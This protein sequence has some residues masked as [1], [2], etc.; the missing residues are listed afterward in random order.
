MSD[1]W[2]QRSIRP[3]RMI[4]EEKQA[5]IEFL[6]RVAALA[7]YVFINLLILSKYSVRYGA[8]V[9]LSCS[10]YV[11][12]LAGAVWIVARDAVLKFLAP[13]IRYFLMVGI[14]S[15]GLALFLSYFNPGEIRV[16]R[17]PAI[18]GWLQD[19][20]SGTYPYG[21]KTHPS[22]FPVLFLVAL[23][24]YW[25]GDTGLWQ[26]ASFAVFAFTLS[27]W[28]PKRRVLGVLLLAGSPAFL[29]EVAVRSDVFSNMVLVLLYLQLVIP[30]TSTQSMRK[31]FAVG[32]LGGLILS[33]RAVVTLTYAVLFLRAARVDLR[34]SLVLASGWAMAFTAS[35]LPFLLWNTD[36]FLASG[37]FVIQSSYLPF[38]VILGL[39]MLSLMAGRLISVD[40]DIVPASSAVLF[41][42]V[43]AAFAFSIVEHGWAAAIY[44]DKFDISYFMIPLPFV[45]LTML[46][47]PQFQRG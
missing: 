34:R 40:R 45:L 3:I 5:R 7:A 1:D 10:A 18:N 46:G 9:F 2:L 41:L 37:P 47:T 36:V 35:I 44:S 6:L 28:F 22:G 17:Y 26:I 13:D 42:A 16:G 25:I 8:P 32:L 4:P 33:T 27:R 24:F 14:L 38:P 12:V 30:I 11:A 23:P 39:S 15:V 31:V 20:F 43:G 21:T 19:L 29:Y